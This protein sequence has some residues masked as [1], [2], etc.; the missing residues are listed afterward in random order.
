VIAHPLK[1]EGSDASEDGTGRGTPLIPIDITNASEGKDIAGTLEASQGKGNKGQGV[2]A[3]GWNKSPSQ[4]MR[5]DDKTDPLQ[6]SPTSNPAIAWHE[7]KQGNLSPG[8]TAKALR[9]GASHSYQGIGVR[10]LTP[11]E[12]ER[13]QGFPDDWTRWG[14]DENGKRSEMS[15]SARYRMLGNAVAVPVVE[16]V[17]KRINSSTTE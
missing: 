7:N 4:T 14:M 11:R 8:D 17:L 3:F 10:R 16:W 15:D 5:V 2:M 13:L 12:C 1:C 9:S 6:E